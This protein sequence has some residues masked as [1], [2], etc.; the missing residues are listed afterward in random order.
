MAKN[1]TT[2][3]GFK[4]LINNQGCVIRECIAETSYTPIDCVLKDYI[5][6]VCSDSKI[7]TVISMEG[8]CNLRLS[9]CVSGTNLLELFHS[10]LFLEMVF[11][12]HSQLLKKKWSEPLSWACIT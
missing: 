4:I 7:L 1:M 12:M 9:L 8:V 10:P 11:H 2:L 5:T 6:C 3:T